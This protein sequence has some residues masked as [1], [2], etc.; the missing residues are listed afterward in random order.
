MSVGVRDETA[1]TCVD[2]LPACFAVLLQNMKIS[3]FKR[4]GMRKLTSLGG[5]KPSDI[6]RGIELARP[7]LVIGAM[8]QSLSF[9]LKTLYP[10]ARALCLSLSLLAMRLYP[11]NKASKR[12]VHATRRTLARSL[13]RCRDRPSICANLLFETSFEK[14]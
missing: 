2:V 3:R 13:A 7:L 11:V 4:R 14:Y 5:R 9:M 1:G 12:K 6:A 8:L 10:V